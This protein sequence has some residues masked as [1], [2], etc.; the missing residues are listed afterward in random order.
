MNSPK[1][2]S[3]L[4]NTMDRLEKI[5]SRGDLDGYEI[6]EILVIAVY[7]KPYEEADQE[8]EPD[9]VESFIFVDGSTQVP[10]TQLGILEMA[11]DTVVHPQ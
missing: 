10:Y 5:E 11:K 1:F 9:A 3:T 6:K 8:I 2:G 7:T 4:A